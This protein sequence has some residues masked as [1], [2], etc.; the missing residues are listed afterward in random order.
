[1]EPLQSQFS[2]WVSSLLHRVRLQAIEL[3]H[4]YTMELQTDPATEGFSVLITVQCQ[5]LAIG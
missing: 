3:V 1:M 2:G 5:L 4:I